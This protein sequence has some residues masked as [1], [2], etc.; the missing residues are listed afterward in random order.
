MLT[1]TQN[2]KLLKILILL[3]KIDRLVQFHKFYVVT[4]IVMLCFIHGNF[5]TEW[6]ETNQ[7]TEKQLVKDYVFTSDSACLHMITL[8]LRYSHPSNYRNCDTMYAF[9][10]TTVIRSSILNVTGYLDVPLVTEKNDLS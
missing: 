10:L 8:S 1:P 6:S 7:K 3:L 5:W 4:V 2:R 9:V